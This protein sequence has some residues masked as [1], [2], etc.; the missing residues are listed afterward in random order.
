MFGIT[1]NFE[2]TS[3]IRESGVWKQISGHKIIPKLAS[4]EC[5][6]GGRLKLST[7]HPPSVG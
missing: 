1:Y 5:N 3:D 7:G 4:S 6:G 2:P